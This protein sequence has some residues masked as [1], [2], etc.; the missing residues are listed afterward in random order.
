MLYFVS[1]V[2]SVELHESGSYGP[3]G[4]IGVLGAAAILAAGVLELGAAR[5]RVHRATPAAAA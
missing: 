1:Q 2:L 5:G 4:V 3:G